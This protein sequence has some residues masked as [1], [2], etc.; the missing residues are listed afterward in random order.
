M[1]G[2]SPP[3]CDAPEIL[4]QSVDRR[5]KLPADQPAT[6]PGV[7]DKVWPKELVAAVPGPS[8]PDKPLVLMR[9]NP[10]WYVMGSS[11][12]ELGRDEAEFP[13]HARYIGP[14]FYMGKHEVTQAQWEAVMGYLP[15]MISGDDRGPDYPVHWVSYVEIGRFVDRVEGY[16]D[17]GSSLNAQAGVEKGNIYLPSEAEWEYAAR[18]GTYTRFFFGDSL[19]CADDDYGE[20]EA[21]DYVGTRYDYM[22]CGGNLE[23]GHIDF[24]EVGQLQPNAWG[25]HDVHGNVFEFVEDHYHS[26]GDP[27]RPSDGNPWCGRLES[28]LPAVR[29]GG[30]VSALWWPDRVVR[31]GSSF[32]P[33]SQCRSAYRGSFAEDER[34]G[35]GGFRLLWNSSGR[36]GGQEKPDFEESEAAEMWSPA[37]ERW[38]IRETQTQAL[39][40]SSGNRVYQMTGNGGGV[41]TFS[42]YNE[43][44]SDA[45][46]HVDVRKMSGD[47]P[48]M[49]YAYGLYVRSDGQQKDYY[50]FSIIVD[51]AYMVGKSVGGN[52]APLVEWT[53]SNALNTGYGA[54]N[55]LQVVAIE[56]TVQFYANGEFLVALRDESFSTGKVGLYAVDASGSTER[57]VVQFDNVRLAGP[58]PDAPEK[59]QVYLPLIAGKLRVAGKPKPGSWAGGGVDFRVTSGSR[60]VDD[61]G[62]RISLPGCGTVTIRKN[63]PVS[64]VNGSFSFTGSFYASGTF[65]SA[66][67][68]SGVVGLKDFYVQGCDT[69]TAK[70]PWTATWKGAGEAA[71]EGSGAGG[72][73]GVTVEEVLLSG[74]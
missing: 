17:V 54:W 61:F 23:P 68:A 45:D 66:T 71:P 20:C 18:A 4:A 53:R 9:V 52:F 41:G 26:W 73:G 27:W 31:G 25:L 40:P 72:A 58:E 47:S 51:G 60:Y 63:T 14:T 37:D 70:G 59:Q 42:H 7:D 2:E 1:P 56:D 10:D 46:Y 34:N 12:D 44:F 35:W 74:P 55:T 22:W 15:A 11:E 65:G 36:W 49:A 39:S 43:A 30:C 16:R 24:S 6:V 32:S 19:G 21:G 28:G 33:A 62:A 3:P 13:L 29:P 67:T 48:E 50:S 57:D 8:S 38:E 5:A 69:Y 64:I